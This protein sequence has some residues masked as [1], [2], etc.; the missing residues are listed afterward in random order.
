MFAGASATTLQDSQWLSALQRAI[1]FVTGLSEDAVEVSAAAANKGIIVVALTAC[2]F[3]PEAASHTA[4][5]TTALYAKWAMV[6]ADLKADSS[7]LKR[8]VL[9]DLGT[10]VTTTA[11]EDMYDPTCTGDGCAKGEDPFEK[12][13]NAAAAAMLSATTVAAVV[14][15]ALLF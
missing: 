13:D 14:F 10:S 4:L 3:Q 5:D 11:T 7:V 15:L 6:V 9:A 8:G 2:P 1:L 12:T